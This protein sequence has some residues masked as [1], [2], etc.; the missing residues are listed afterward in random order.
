MHKGEII[1]KL[2]QMRSED[3]SYTDGRILSSVSTKPLNVAIKA[4]EIFSDTNA[5]MSMCSEALKNWRGGSS[6]G[7]VNC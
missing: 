6:N 4:Y 1:D 2:R 7:S 3:Q 5:W